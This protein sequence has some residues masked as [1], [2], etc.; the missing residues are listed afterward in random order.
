MF[1]NAF[2]AQQL[3]A[4]YFMAVIQAD[5]ACMIST[6]DFDR[7]DGLIMLNKLASLWFS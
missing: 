2:L 1:F 5:G 3:E 7:P 4:G 6:G